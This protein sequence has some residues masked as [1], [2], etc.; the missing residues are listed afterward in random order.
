MRTA[1]LLAGSIAAFCLASSAQAAD[2]AVSKHKT[3]AVHAPAAEP[4]CIRWVEQTYSWYNYC[5]SVPYY[6]RRKVGWLGFF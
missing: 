2:L 1:L 5:D 3:A 4:V 6:S